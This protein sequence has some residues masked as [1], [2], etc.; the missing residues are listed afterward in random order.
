MTDEV[1]TSHTKNLGVLNSHIYFKPNKIRIQKMT[2]FMT[3]NPECDCENNGKQTI[4][5]DFWE[6][7]CI[8]SYID[9]VNEVTT[10]V[11]EW[12]KRF[13]TWNNKLITRCF[14]RRINLIYCDIIFYIVVTVL[15]SLYEIINE[16]R[17]HSV[18][19]G[20][21]NLLAMENEIN[22]TTRVRRVFS[23]TPVRYRRPCFTLSRIRPELFHI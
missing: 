14:Q 8:I 20:V 13:N 6:F 9:D 23:S 5:R 15:F 19:V 18:R 2:F 12:T 16:H 21:P 1:K 7:S 10:V 3:D 17:P 4:R 11:V 22:Q